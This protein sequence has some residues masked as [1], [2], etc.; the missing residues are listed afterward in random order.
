VLHALKKVPYFIHINVYADDSHKFSFV[1]TDF[2]CAN[3]GGDGGV[4]KSF[5]CSPF[6]FYLAKLFISC[7][8]SFSS[9]FV[10]TDKRERCWPQYPVP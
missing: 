9:N 3:D 2:F 8:S 1:I 6:I 10:P 4:G 7:P 5:Y